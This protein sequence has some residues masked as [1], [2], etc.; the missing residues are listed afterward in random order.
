MSYPDVSE[1]GLTKRGFYLL[2]AALAATVLVTYA[3]A[4]ESHGVDYSK[5]KMPN[6]PYASCCNNQDC[7]TTR[8][9]RTANGWEAHKRETNQWISVPDNKYDER[10]GFSGEG[11]P[12]DGQTHLCS[13][14]GADTVYCFQPGGGQ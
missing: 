8:A 14:A 12:D 9:R 3:F 1:P 11:A 6:A 5:W 2:V 4:H 7:Y 10:T 13:P